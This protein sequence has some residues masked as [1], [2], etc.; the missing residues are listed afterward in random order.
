MVPAMKQGAPGSSLSLL[1]RLMALSTSGF[2]IQAGC[3]DRLSLSL[4]V[5]RHGQRQQMGGVTH[6]EVVQPELFQLEAHVLDGCERL[7][8]DLAGHQSRHRVLAQHDDGAIDGGDLDL[9][10]HG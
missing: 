8:H 3:G 4:A 7:A 10:S 9:H 1:G 6:G 5:C 2:I